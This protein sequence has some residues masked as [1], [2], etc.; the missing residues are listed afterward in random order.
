MSINYNRTWWGY[1]YKYGGFLIAAGMETMDGYIYNSKSLAW[2][3]KFTMTNVRLGLGLGGGLGA[4]A[5]L[6]FNAP[7]LAALDGMQIN[8]WGVNISMGAKV[9]AMAKAMSKSHLLPSDMED[10][11]NG[12]HY[13]YT[14]LDISGR[15]LSPKIVC[16]DLGGIG[17]EVSVNYVTGKF[18]VEWGA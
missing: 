4:V 9:S 7:S 11:R 8:D 1:G 2:S 16:I 18:E 15:D 3:E 14:S 5:I 6:A 10:V 12:L 17:A 13:I